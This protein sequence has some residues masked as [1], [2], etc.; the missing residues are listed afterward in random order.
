M[1][2]KLSTRDELLLGLQQARS[3]SRDEALDVWNRHVDSLRSAVVDSDRYWLEDRIQDVECD[4]GFAP[5]PSHISHLLASQGLSYLG[6]E[7]PAVGP[8]SYF[9]L[10]GVEQA[11]ADRPVPERGNGGFDA[12]T[13]GYLIPTRTAWFAH[14]VPGAADKDIQH[15]LALMRGELEALGIRVFAPE[16]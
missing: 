3:A 8:H 13:W 6:H 14:A 12:S 4:L 11:N 16:H 5:H 10:L 15:G 1:P 7:E 2:S 9:E